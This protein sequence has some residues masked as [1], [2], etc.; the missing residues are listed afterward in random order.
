MRLGFGYPGWAK[1]TI[2]EN[3]DRKS[4]FVKMPN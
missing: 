2:I 1:K 4:E 3:L